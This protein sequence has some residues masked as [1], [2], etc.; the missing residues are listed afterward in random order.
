MLFWLFVIALV[1]GASCAVLGSWMYDNTK[2]DTD[3]LKII[4]LI[5][6]G[7]TVVAISISGF[8][9]IDSYGD[10][11]AMVAQNHKRYESLV[12][13]LENNLYDNDNDLGKKEL[14]NEIRE[15]NEDLAY[16]QNIQDSFWLGI[17]Y[18]N[19]FDQFEFIELGN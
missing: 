7:V 17:Y 19:V 1:V 2:Y 16:Y 15:W 11:E 10:A 13:Q 9:M 18:P 12:Y 8:V 4:G 6:V 5:I 3:W 14:Y